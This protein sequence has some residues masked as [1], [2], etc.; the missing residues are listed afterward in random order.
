VHAVLPNIVRHFMASSYLDTEITV[1]QAQLNILFNVTN[2][3]P[4][5]AAISPTTLC[6]GLSTLQVSV[7]NASYYFYEQFETYNIRKKD[8]M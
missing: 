4:D 2:L 7:L 6:V 1:L 5:S 3:D 8:C